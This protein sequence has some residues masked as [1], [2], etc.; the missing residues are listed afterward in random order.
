MQ[1]DVYHEANIRRTVTTLCHC[2]ATVAAIFTD[3]NL[4]GGVA[5][6]AANALLNTNR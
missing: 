1:H 2:G 6:R 3:V 5:D 4:L